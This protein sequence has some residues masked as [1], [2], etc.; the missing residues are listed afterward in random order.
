MSDM[1]LSRAT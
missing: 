1:Q